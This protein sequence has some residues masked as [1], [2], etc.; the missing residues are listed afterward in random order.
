M[1]PRRAVIALSATAVAVALLLNF[2]TPESSLQ[3]LN[4]GGAAS[5]GQPSVSG[6]VAAPAGGLLDQGSSS[7]ASGAPAASSAPAASQGAS[8][9][10]SGS[11]GSGG[12][13]AGTAGGLKAG[14]FAGSTIQT[15]FGNVQVQVTVSGG[16]I[17][18]VQ[19]LQTPSMHGRSIMIN[20]YAA[21][22]LRQEALTAQSAQIDIVSG[23][24][25]TSEG[26][27]QSLQSALD[28]AHA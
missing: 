17:V 28:Q 24:T 5:V 3:A 26:Y 13:A 14:T 12:S 9:S 10:G 16:K 22:I 8:T 7:T 1:L 21:P 19:A 18:D 15:P 20:A 11:A 6:A 4:G 2:R 25:Y 27:A 23:A